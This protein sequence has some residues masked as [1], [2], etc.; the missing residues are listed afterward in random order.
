VSDDLAPL[1]LATTE[2]LVRELQSRS[3][4]CI[5]AY[6]RRQGE[7]QHFMSYFYGGVSACIGL[8]RRLGNRLETTYDK[9]ES[10][11]NDD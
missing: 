4:H 10:E 8:C 9:D 3:D 7:Q 6:E 5:V 11:M 1:S 2:E